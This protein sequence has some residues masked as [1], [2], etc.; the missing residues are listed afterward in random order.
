MDT[1]FWCSAY[2]LSSSIKTT[3]QHNGGTGMPVV[4]IDVTPSLFDILSR[5]CAWVTDDEAWRSI[6]GEFGSSVY[7]SQVREAVAKK[8]AE[9]CTWMLLVG[10]R[11]ERVGILNLRT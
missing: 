3:F 10:V 5:N 1:D 7:A 8:K 11:E 6:A 2:E 9:G 4:A